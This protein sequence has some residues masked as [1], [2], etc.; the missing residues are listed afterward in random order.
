LARPNGAYKPGVVNN[1]DITVAKAQ[2]TLRLN[3]GSLGAGGGNAPDT[4][5]KYGPIA[6]YVGGTAP[7]S[8]KDLA[9]AD[10][11]ARPYE[12]EKVGTNFRM[13]KLSE[14]YYG[15]SAAIADID[16][17]GN[18][19]VISGPIIY[20]GPSF[21]VGREYYAG[22]TYNPT[23]EWPIASMVN[24]AY[25]WTGDGWIDMLNMS[26]NAGVGTGTLA[27]NPRGENRRW[28]LAPVMVPPA[29]TIGNE[30]TL[31]KDIDGDGKPE[32]IHTGQNTLRYSK[33]DPANPTGPWIVKTIS[34]P[35]PWGV[36]IGH[37]MGIGDINADGRADYV[38]T[39]GWWEQ[40][41]A[42]NTGLWTH[43]PEQ[44]GRWGASQGGAGGAEIGIYDVNGDRLNDVVSA[45]EGHGFGLA[46]W[47]QK[48][49]AAGKITFVQHTIM[50]TALDATNAGGVWF[51]QPHA[52]T[53]ADM[54]RDGIQ[55]M[56]VGK[57][58]HSH[59][60][61]AD[62]DNWGM[63]V[64]YWYRTVRNAR[65]PGGAEFVP[66]LI[67]NRSGVGSHIGLGDLD[68]NGTT[69]IAVSG[70]SGT[71]VFFNNIPRR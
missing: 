59:F 10:L 66:N 58:H 54:D 13:R 30:E 14:F 67:S 5:G 51:T 8:F 4:V 36:N 68:K 56:I 71:F 20:Y 22:I 7:A 24:L 55:D 44:F 46:W 40:P 1:T 2:V 28:D 37:G 38:T 6:L 34:E 63:P 57:R 70:A 16:K 41:P 39:Y 48:K 18:Q 49:D 23:S 65:A 21:N 29:G 17:D 32:L 26:G 27:I 62:P 43:H 69:D 47:E 53:F 35:G 45:M 19:D 3:G 64:L 61:Y 52:V 42:G 31:L 33:A 15:Y 25:D 12:D 50:D 11:N 9:Y 60:Q